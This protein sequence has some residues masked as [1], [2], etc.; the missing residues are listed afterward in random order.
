QECMSWAALIELPIV[1]GEVQ[2]VGPGSGI[3]SLP[4]H[5]D[6]TQMR[7]GGNGDY[8]VVV[9]AP[10]SCQ[11]LFDLSFEAFNIADEWRV[12]TI[13]MSDALLGHIHEKVVIPPADEMRKRIRLRKAYKPGDKIKNVYTITKDFEEFSIPPLPIIGTDPFPWWV[14]SV[15]HSVK[16]GLITEDADV[17][18]ECIQIKSYKILKNESKIAMVEKYNLDDADVAIVAYGIPSRTAIEAMN[19]CRKEGLKVGFFRMKTVWPIPV[20]ELK[21]LMEQVKAIVF[22]EI[23]LGQIAGEIERYACVDGKKVPVHLIPH[24]S[25]LHTPEQIINKIKEV[26]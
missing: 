25:G 11:E 9:L 21:Q 15:T 18:F 6:V 13:I 5:G 24:T 3:V 26:I 17:A 10:A 12:P 16:N 8:E 22:P 23:N 1:I 2:R 20:T 19:R 4:H 7:R 14:P